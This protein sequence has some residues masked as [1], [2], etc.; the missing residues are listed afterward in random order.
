MGRITILLAAPLSKQSS[1]Q[2]E[3]SENAKV[4]CMYCHTTDETLSSPFTRI[5]RQNSCS[6]SSETL[7]TEEETPSPATTHRENNMNHYL[8]GWHITDNASLSSLAAEDEGMVVLSA[9]TNSSG[10]VAEMMMVVMMMP[11][12]QRTLLRKNHNLTDLFLSNDDVVTA[13]TRTRRQR[14]CP[15]GLRR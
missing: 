5:N 6:Q 10:S 8:Y 4:R 15:G 3:P 2:H 9:P 13:T 7:N 12:S 1:K 11:R 14:I